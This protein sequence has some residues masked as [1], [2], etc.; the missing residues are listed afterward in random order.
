[1][2]ANFP[3][4]GCDLKGTYFFSAYF[5]SDKVTILK[6]VFAFNNGSIFD[7]RIVTCLYS[8]IIQYT[9]LLLDG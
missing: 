9:F 4:I 2:L 5:G 3:P 7:D 1:M 8:E 6:V